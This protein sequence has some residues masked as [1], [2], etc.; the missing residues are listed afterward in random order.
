M[1][2]S[3]MKI[4]KKDD[5]VGIFYVTKIAGAETDGVKQGK[6]CVIDAAM[7]RGRW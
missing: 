7:A 2:T 4:I 3:A 6:D 1:T 5:S